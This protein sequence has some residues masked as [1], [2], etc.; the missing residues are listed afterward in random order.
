MGLPNNLLLLIAFFIVQS[1]LWISFMVRRY[2]PNVA[3]QFTITFLLSIILSLCL[4]I[5]GLINLK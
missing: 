3:Y 5:W 2:S 1:A 4:V